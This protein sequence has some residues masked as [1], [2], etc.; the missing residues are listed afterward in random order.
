M[1]YL[2][3]AATTPIDPRVRKAMQPFLEGEYGNP[4]S[5]Y[6]LGQNARKA[7]ETARTDLAKILNARNQEIIF[8]AGGTES[9]NLAIFGIVRKYLLDNKNKKP[10]IITTSI[11]HHAVLESFTALKKEGVEVTYI[12]PD[13]EGFVTP[14][15]IVKAIKA[16]TILVSVMYANNEI[17]T[18]E[19]IAKI[20]QELRKVNAL[21]LKKKQPQIL[22]HSDACQGG[23]ALTLDV[24]KL[25]LDLMTVNSSKVYGPKQV[26]LLYVRS[27]VEILP[28]I[29]GG[30]QERGL[31]SGTENIAGIV[32]FAKALQIAESDREKENAR[33]KKLRDYL[34]QNISKKIP[35]SYLNGPIEE[36]LP[37]NINFS[38]PGAEGEALVLYLDAK[39][40]LAST[41]SACSST[42]QDPSHVILKIGK[43]YEY[44]FGSVRFTLGR[45]TTKADIDKLLKILPPLVKQLRSVQGL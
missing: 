39:G 24:Q 27:G 2:D 5:I 13:S 19:P 15:D 33:L 32:G 35:Q 6:S 23:G 29:Y 43:P 40:I 36:R 17:G 20:G 26:A 3:Y 44:A 7:L 4:S 45:K 30:G 34:I 11:E 14:Q 8:S 41:G 28:L 22:F 18:I 16:N 12:N 37:N 25:G 9:I 1:I 21:R 10:H 38:F 31:R 42:S